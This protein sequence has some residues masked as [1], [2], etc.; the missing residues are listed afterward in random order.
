MQAKKR[1]GK[2]TAKGF[3]IRLNVT[4][5]RTFKVLDIAQGADTRQN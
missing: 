2:L 5:S 1:V 3:T 4:F